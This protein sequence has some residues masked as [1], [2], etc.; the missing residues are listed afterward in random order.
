MSEHFCPE[1]AASS[2]QPIA[3]TNGCHGAFIVAPAIRA[4][5]D[6]SSEAD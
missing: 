5:V 4:E 3:I 6:S 2:K 1:Q